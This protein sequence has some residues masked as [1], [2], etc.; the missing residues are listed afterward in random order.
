MHCPVATMA[1]IVVIEGSDSV[2][3][4]LVVAMVMIDVIEGRE[5]VFFVDWWQ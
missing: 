4:G 5:S 3:C 1:M 2:F